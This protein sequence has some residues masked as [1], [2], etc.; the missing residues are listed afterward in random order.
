MVYSTNE[1]CVL[2]QNM[3]TT[4]K[5]FNESS[6]FL[7]EVL[8][9]KLSSCWYQK[10]GNYNENVN[11][12]VSIQRINNISTALTKLQKI[13]L[14]DLN[15]ME[16]TILYSALTEQFNQKE[17]FY[18]RDV[19]DNKDIYSY[20]LYLNSLTDSTTKYKDKDGT[21]VQV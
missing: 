21:E 11:F 4:Q 14:I 1:M 3:F 12:T 8:K 10:E 15:K 19:V 2:Q 7:N 6:L 17:S 16:S 13:Q 20:R 5:A 18:S 9:N